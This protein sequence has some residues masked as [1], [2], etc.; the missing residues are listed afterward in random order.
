[1]S[2]PLFLVA[3]GELPEA[4]R[5]E[6][7][8]DEG[9]HAAKVRRLR[10]GEQLELGDG[11]GVVARCE[12]VAVG[13]GLTVEV[14]ERRVVPAPAVRV[15][16]AQALPKGERGELAVELATELGVD[17]IVPWAAARCVAK[18]EGPKAARNAERWAA[19]ARE[20]A[21]QAR[22]PWVP[23]VEPLADTA[24]LVARGAHAIVLHEAATEPLV[25]VPLPEAGEIL[26]VVGPEGGI[27]EDEL[28]RLAEAGARTC[29]LGTE[30]LRTSTA[31]AAA[32]AALS[33]RLG[34]W[35]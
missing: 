35:A 20:A 16:L 6:L 18:W 25:E 21:K 26:L 11:A 27:S 31:G 22:R 13:A 5:Y 7:G 33:V 1:M 32:L 34:R 9:R 12:V 8:G 17:A 14:L 19:H 28:A 23:T 4:G 30:V 10:I 3:Q 2:L 29:R 24:A 15:T